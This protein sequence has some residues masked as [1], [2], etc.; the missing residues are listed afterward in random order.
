MNI[1]AEILLLRAIRR[2]IYYCEMFLK[3]TACADVLVRSLK[4]Q[5]LNPKP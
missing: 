4:T 1:Y 2:D 5:T 3:P